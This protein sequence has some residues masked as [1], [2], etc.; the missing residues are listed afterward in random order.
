MKVIVLN[1]SGDFF[2]DDPVEVAKCPVC[3]HSVC[4]EPY[5]RVKETRSF[6]NASFYMGYITKSSISCPK[7][8][9]HLSVMVPASLGALPD[10]WEVKHV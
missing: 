5:R 7:C 1:D 3:N 10:G 2:F 8:G 4:I 9:H 6:W